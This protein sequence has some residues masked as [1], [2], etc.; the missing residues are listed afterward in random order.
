V[1]TK[2]GEMQIL[3]FLS[4]N[5]SGRVLDRLTYDNQVFGGIVMGIGFGMTEFR[6]LDARQTGR[7]C[8]R[9]WHDYKLPTALDVPVDMESL[10]IEI[11]DPKA[12]NTG[13]KGLGEPVT[14]PTAAA[15]ANAL[16]MATGIRFTRA[17]VTPIEM[18][19]HLTAIK[20]G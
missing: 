19:R 14:I 18:R 2:T 13:T 17:P 4:A 20:E 11:D 7:L 5:D 15:I 1:N 3:R 10:P 6:Q 12:N 16:F 9:N 8:N